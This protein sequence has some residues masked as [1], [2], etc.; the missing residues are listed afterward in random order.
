[1]AS[2]V[3]KMERDFSQPLSIAELASSV[4]MSERHFRRQFEYIYQ[5][6][7]KAYLLKIR[8]NAAMQML[9]QTDYAISDIA[10]VC[11]FSDCNHFSRVFRQKFGASPTEYRKHCE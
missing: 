3:A 9:I 11:G 2:A 4:Y 10:L 5:Q 7:P 1:M 6:S 8:L